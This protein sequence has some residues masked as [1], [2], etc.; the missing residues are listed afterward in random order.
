MSIKVSKRVWRWSAAG[1]AG[2]AVLLAGQAWAASSTRSSA[3]EYDAATGLLVK[4]IV[5]P[6]NSQ[7]CVVTT[8]TYDAFGNRKTATTRNCNGSPGSHPGVNSEAAAPAAPA[9]FAARTAS[10]TYTADGRFVET[11]TNALNQTETKQYDARFGAVTKLT[12]PN[13]LSTEWKY[14]GFGR[15][16]LEK[17]ADGTG[18]KWEYL[19]CSGVNGGTASCPTVAGAAGKYL[20]RTTPVAGPIDMAAGTTGAAN[21]PSSTVY[22]DG[23]G[24]DIRT[25]TQGY[26]GNGAAATIYQDTEYNALGQVKRVSKPY[27]A[28]QTV[29]WLGE[30][31]YDE[32]DRLKTTTTWDETGTART[33]TITYN[34]LVIT[35]TD[36]RGRTY[37]KTK[38]VAGQL[39]K[40]TDSHNKTLTYHYDEQ[41]NLTSTV[42]PAGNVSSIS[43]DLRGRKTGISD[44]DMGNWTYGYNALG[45]LVRQT[46]AKNQISTISYDVLGRMTQ[47]TEPDLVSNWYYDKTSAGAACGKSVGKLCEA[48]TDAGYKRVHNY[49]A[50]G[51]GN[52]TATTLDTVYT[53]ST[54]FDTQ[55]RVATQVYPSGLTLKY[56]Y[57]PLGYLKEVRNNA[58]NALYWQANTF[59]AEGQLVKQT[60]GNGV[61]TQHAFNAYTGRVIDTTAGTGNA[62][63]NL[64]Y[65]YDNAG[66][67]SVRQDRN[68]NLVETFDYDDL[69]RLKS[70]SLN[71]SATG[72]VTT[73]FA[74]DAL[75]NL[76]CKSDLSAC[77]ATTPNLVYGAQVTVNG[78][79]RTLPHAVKNVVGTVHGQANPSY[80]Y[81]A[82]GAMLT[83]AGRTVSYT[84]YGMSAQITAPGKNG[85]SYIY[86][87]EHQRI[88]ENTLS[89]TGATL[90][91]TYYLHPDSANGLSYEVEKAGTATTHKHYITAGGEVMALVTY[92]GTAWVNKYFHRDNLGSTTAVTDQTGAVLERMAYD[93]WGK[94]RN[95]NGVVDPNDTLAGGQTDRGYTNH[96]HID[97]LGLIN[98]NGRVFDPA[99]ARFMAADPFIQAPES[100]QSYNRYSYVMNNPF[101]GTDPTGYFSLNPFKHA[102]KLDKAL[103]KVGQ[104]TIDVM[105]SP[106]VANH[107]NWMAAQPGQKA[108]DRYVMTHSWAYSAGSVIT[109][110]ATFWCYGCGGALYSAYYTYQYTGSATAGVKAGAIAMATNYAFSYVGAQNWSDP[111]KI[112]A[113]AAIGCGSAAASGGSCRSGALAAGFGK[114]ATVGATA[115]GWDWVSHPSGFSDRAAG[116]AFASVVGGTASMLGGGSFE[117]GAMTAAFGYLFNQLMSMSEAELKEHFANKSRAASQQMFA[118]WETRQSNLHMIACGQAACPPATP[119]QVATMVDALKVAGQFHPGTRLVIEVIDIGVV[120]V[121]VAS[122]NW[123]KAATGAS[124]IFGGNAVK[125]AFRHAGSEAAGRMGGL[126][127]IVIEKGVGAYMEG[128]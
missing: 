101:G 29:Y 43:Y 100:I 66:R 117:N 1:C 70:V 68:Q 54:T 53:A 67:L 108:V 118:D 75:G 111:T 126:Q 20:V 87:P 26:D 49:D 112:A 121:D 62:V 9:A 80:T 97:S 98:M 13:G 12:G 11:T 99:L 6:G 109:T 22:F 83:G 69:N 94:R 115:A 61:I 14:D 123:S 72:F 40:V 113:H 28:G 47:R 63:Q 89:P 58:T 106:T 48:K 92:N 41:G 50:L 119:E 55:G 46:D 8:Y 103:R 42:D 21:G 7:L 102:K 105:K 52:T 45:E 32:L 57:T 76:T 5:E 110:A 93:P 30:Y 88:R 120:G 65:A 19:F 25:E 27:F 16:V 31:T 39:W 33:E 79:T 34:G 10:N 4:E 59:N 125:R 38:N 127:G 124:G 114:A 15:K 35:T 128:K 77:N 82:N 60:Y 95:P 2:A 71:A 64:G 73:S 78:T 84:S 51:R 44:P 107:F 74:Y 23:L 90:S 91:T 104:A 86:G 96:E 18:T 116:V 56:V 17:R 24:R 3:F 37:T 122:G 36:H 81:D 85:V